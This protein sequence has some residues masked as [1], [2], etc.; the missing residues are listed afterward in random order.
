M[1][2]YLKE[3]RGGG[4]EKWS[5]LGSGGGGEEWYMNSSVGVILGLSA[6]TQSNTY[7][8]L[9]NTCVSKLQGT[10][11][12]LCVCQH[13]SVNECVFVCK[14]VCANTMTDLTL[15]HKLPFR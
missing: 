4:S 13:V 2:G 1:M 15:K 7:T 9:P 5:R 12:S 14:F 8:A 6:N 10:W 3:T 11:L